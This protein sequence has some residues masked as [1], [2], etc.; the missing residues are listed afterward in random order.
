MNQKRLTR[1]KLDRESGRIDWSRD[2]WHLD[3]LI[4][5]MNPWPGAFTFIPTP[6]DSVKKLKIHR[7]LPIHRASGDEGVVHRIEHRGV[8]VTCGRGAL[9][10]LE[11]QLE[12]KRRMSAVEF[13]R[14]FALP[15][16]RCWARKG[17]GQRVG[18]SA[19]G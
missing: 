3:R 4:R 11:V 17:A 2:C 8:V 18:I 5:A 10:L 19:S 16:G 15:P 13:I 14:G 6:G 12:G 1:A 7:A 9:L